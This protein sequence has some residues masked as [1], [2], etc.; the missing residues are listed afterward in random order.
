MNSGLQDT[1]PKVRHVLNIAGL[2]GGAFDGDSVHVAG[3]YAR[4]DGGGGHLT[5]AA[6][7]TAT[8]DAGMIFAVAGITTGRWL[9]SSATGLIN[10]RWFGCKAD[11]TTDDTTAA[12]ACINAAGAI[13]GRAYFP[14]GLYR[15]SATLYLPYGVTIEGDGM[16]EQLAG[17]IYKTTFFMPLSSFTA[18]DVFRMSNTSAF[19]GR[20]YWSGHIHK[21]S[22]RGNTTTAT[23]QWGISFRD[24]AGNGVTPQD[25]TCLDLLHIRGCFSGGIE[26]PNG[27]LPLTVSRL[28]LLCNNGPGILFTGGANAH[29]TINFDEVSGDGNN[30]GLLSFVNLDNQGAVIINA[31]KSEMRANFEYA[32][33]AMQQN[34]IVFTNCN[35]TPVIINGAT[36]ISSVPDTINPAVYQKPGDLITFSSTV[37]PLITW[38]AVAIRVRGTD[39]GTSPHVLVAG[40]N[41]FVPYS[42]SAGVFLGSVAGS[43]AQLPICGL[44]GIQ[45]VVGQSGVWTGTGGVSY[46]LQ[47]QGPNPGL[48]WYD[49]NGATNTHKWIFQSINGALHLSAVDDAGAVVDIMQMN[50]NAGAPTSLNVTVPVQPGI[51]TVFGLPTATNYPSKL[52]M[53]S[54]PAAGKGRVVYSD[55]TI[56]RYVSD[57]SA[58]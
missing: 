30:G 4:G 14:A 15:T 8:A 9:R 27:A 16:T 40:A 3:Y 20:Y 12:Q 18:G 22:I 13:G 54:N 32:N 48:E 31:L 6:A 19:G 5:W 21:I 2:T 45:M 55:G 1:R 35:G 26:M 10:A 52:T 51:Y 39:T 38:N 33:V 50:R 47:V 58:V 56:W 29:Q 44:N 46:G 25:T 11:G 37:T 23:A 36:H 7:S 17:P 49:T 41:T 42:R 57:D 28:K 34:A 43:A 24:S 53:V